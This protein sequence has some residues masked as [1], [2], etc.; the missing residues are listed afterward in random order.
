M[1][2]DNPHAILA[3]VGKMVSEIS[4]KMCD[5]K[6]RPG[7]EVLRSFARVVN[8]YRQLYAEIKKDGRF[9]GEDPESWADDQYLDGDPNYHDSLYEND[10]R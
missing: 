10:E 3:E 5:G 7:S 8:S 9:L 1:K 2:N 6:R 4:Q